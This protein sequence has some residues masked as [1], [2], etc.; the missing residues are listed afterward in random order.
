MALILS[1][2]CGSCVNHNDRL[3]MEMVAQ[4]NGLPDQRYSFN[5][6]Y[7]KHAISSYKTNWT[8]PPTADVNTLVNMS[9]GDFMA[10]FNEYG[11]LLSAK[12]SHQDSA[13][14]NPSAPANRIVTRSIA[15]SS[16]VQNLGGNV[17][18]FPFNIS[19]AQTPLCIS[20]SRA[21]FNNFKTVA[22]FLYRTGG[23][24]A[25]G[26]RASWTAIEVLVRGRVGQPNE[27]LS[28]TEVRTL[29][30]RLQQGGALQQL[31]NAETGAIR[32]AQNVGNR[33]NPD[34]NRPPFR[35]GW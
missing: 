2:R 6:S 34:P 14:F 12:M 1:V 21:A 3:E 19:P 5:V 9:E 23:V 30:V 18:C 16:D 33:P 11:R 24:Q 25:A 13:T 8:P 35:S 22:Q 20:L 7:K 10:A 17:H 31:I 26:A 29:E 4:V 15:F 28:S 27:L 32:R